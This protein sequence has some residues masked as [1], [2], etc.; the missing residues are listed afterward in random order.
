MDGIDTMRAAG[1]RYI[2]VCRQ[3]LTE[4]GE[5]DEIGA[6]ERFAPCGT[7][8]LTAPVDTGELVQP[9]IDAF[10]DT[11]PALSV[12][13][14]LRDRP[15]RWIDEGTDVVLSTARRADSRLIAIDVGEVRS[16]LVAAPCYFAPH[17]RIEM[18]GDL[19]GLNAEPEPHAAVWVTTRAAE[20]ATAHRGIQ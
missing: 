6:G 17:P 3:V 15:I 20:V 9:I 14:Y 16:V 11:H 7:V 8:T 5:A 19:A 1:E 18:P 2:V 4:L 13:R 12:L 10:V